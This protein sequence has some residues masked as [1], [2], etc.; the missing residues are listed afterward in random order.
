[1]DEHNHEEQINNMREHID[2]KVSW[3]QFWAVASAMIGLGLLTNS[4]LYSRIYRNDGRIDQILEDEGEHKA[5][6]ARIEVQLA[7]IQKDIAALQLDLHEH[8]EK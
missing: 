4:F 1:M 6:Y 7:T 3:T 5:N 2:R 8:I